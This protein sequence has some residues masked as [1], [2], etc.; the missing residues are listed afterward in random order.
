MTA[1]VDAMAEG[2]ALIDEQ[3]LFLRRDPATVRLPG[4]P[5]G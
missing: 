1:V 5:P 3:G 4:G 2:V